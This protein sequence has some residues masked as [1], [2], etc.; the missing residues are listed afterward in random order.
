LVEAFLEEDLPSAG[1]NAAASTVLVASRGVGRGRLIFVGATVRDLL[2]PARNPE[3]FLIPL[4]GLRLPTIETGMSHASCPL[5]PHLQEVVGFQATGASYL[6][7]AF[8]MSLVYLFGSTF[9]SWAFLKSQGRQQHNW[10]LFAVLAI[11]ASLLSVSAVQ[12]V[13][14][15]G[16]RLHQLSVVD[17]SAGSAEAVATAYFGLKTGLYSEVD[18]WLPDDTTSA[19]ESP[20]VRSY[21][22][23]MIEMARDLGDSQ[24][25]FTDPAEYRLRPA[26]AKLDDVPVRATLKRLEGRWSGTITG[27]VQA[28]IRVLRDSVGS[29]DSQTGDDANAL[30]VD[31]IA[32]ESTITNHLGVDLYDCY[33][34][35][36]E[37]DAFDKERGFL[38][39]SPRGQKPTA[40]R[41]AFVYP[42]G[43][44]RDGETI[45]VADRI[46]RDAAGRPV[47][48]RDWIEKNTM[49]ARHEQWNSPFR[50]FI[51]AADLPTAGLDSARQNFQKALLLLTTLAEYDPATQRVSRYWDGG[52]EL[53]PDRCRELDLSDRLTRHAMILVGFAN[54]GGPVK[55]FTRT[56]G[57]EYERRIPA[58]A[59]TMYRVVIPVS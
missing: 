19:A 44:I 9:G 17:I 55:L 12:A 24:W 37:V 58:E 43:G 26:S 29:E 49:H 57:R 15:V 42:L 25:H 36:A 32:P 54:H 30:V 28:S 14:G 20:D 3:S 59:W 10:T 34:I 23:P 40:G 39:R 16:Q 41:M 8:L 13:R 46:T 50:S 4:L 2:E 38:C 47:R 45:R 11:I 21:V 52:L 51:F 27:S 18:V 33:L 7:L 5:F 1:A 53:L 22:R 35:Q 31:E 6:A 48:R 56:G